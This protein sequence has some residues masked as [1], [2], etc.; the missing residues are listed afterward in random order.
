MKQNRGYLP[1]MAVFFLILLGGGWF[2]T[3]QNETS[4][5]EK[6]DYSSKTPQ[7][8]VGH[9]MNQEQ[10]Y[11][12]ASQKMQN[13]EGTLQFQQYQ[14]LVRSYNEQKKVEG[15]LLET[16]I[17]D[18]NK[19]KLAPGVDLDSDK[20]IEHVYEDTQRNYLDQG[21][22]PERYFHSKIQEDVESE[23]LADR[24]DEQFIKQF[25]DNARKDGYA[26]KLDKNLNVVGIKEIGRQPQSESQ[27]QKSQWYGGGSTH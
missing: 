14:R 26:I 11:K 27:S 1:E 24:V 16:S 7:S 2:I 15:A 8:Q 13:L 25:I 20:T 3:H 17:Q 9:R 10:I 23:K 18:I 4:V 22:V 5:V 19:T 6:S 12:E 21:L